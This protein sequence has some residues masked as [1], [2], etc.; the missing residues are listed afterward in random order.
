MENLSINKIGWAVGLILFVVLV[1]FVH[2]V[3]VLSL[4]TNSIYDQPKKEVVVGPAY[5]AQHRFPY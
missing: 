5:G 2:F 3:P 4:D 1:L